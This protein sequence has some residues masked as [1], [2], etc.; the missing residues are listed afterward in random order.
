MIAFLIGLLPYLAPISLAATGETIG[1]KS[2][3]INIGLDG[4]LIVS[5]FVAVEVSARTGSAY[6]GLLA[7][8]VCGIIISLIQAL[9]TL[10]LAADQIVVGTAFNLAGLGLT[11]TLFQAIYGAQGSLIQAPA[12]PDIFGFATLPVLI[13]PLLVWG[14]YYLLRRTN[15]GL[16]IRAAGEYPD[17]VHAAGFSVK[18]L[19]YQAQAMGG[20][21]AGLA[22]AALTLGIT[23]A[24]SEQMVPRGF[25]AIAMVTFGRWSPWKVLWATLLVA[26]TEAL[27]FVLQGHEY[28]LPIQFY[29]AMPYLVALLVLLIV[30]KGSAMPKALGVPLKE[31]V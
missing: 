4:N 22:G 11:G 31:S 1:E 5:A 24:F 29:K 6:L 7:A 8:I 20:F 10:G 9:F 26:V 23:P 16:A 27:Q 21:F 30:G 14:T 3:V 28:G 12:L 17:A 2:G 13:L 25:I 15:W 18:T 19:R